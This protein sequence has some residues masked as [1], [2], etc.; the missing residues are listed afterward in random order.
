[1]NVNSVTSR[2]HYLTRSSEVKESKKNNYKDN[3]NTKKEVKDEYIPSPKEE[4]TVTYQKPTIKPDMVTIQRLK[5]ESERTHSQLK[6]M[7]R[8]LLEKQGLTFKDL[9]GL[10]TVVEID[11]ETRL[12]AQEMIAEGGPLS[13]EKVSDNIVAFAKAISGGDPDKIDMLISAIE[14]GFK[15]ASNMLGGELPEISKKTYDL[16]MEKMEAWRE[17]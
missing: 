10:E 5:E 12:K 16:V 3:D 14:K 11:E 6:E 9:E 1:M 7:V 4:R 8:Q 15:E 13:P 2:D 17:E